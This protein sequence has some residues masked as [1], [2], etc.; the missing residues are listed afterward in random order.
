[1]YLLVCNERS[2]VYQIS[3]HLQTSS[4]LMMGRWWP[5]NVCCLRDRPLCNYGHA[6]SN[7]SYWGTLMYPINI[8]CLAI[9]CPLVKRHLNGVLLAG[10]KWNAFKCYF[11]KLGTLMYLLVCNERSL[12][13]QISLHLQTSRC[14]MA[15]RWWPKAV[16][17]LR[18]RLLCNYR[19][20]TRY[21]SYWG[22]LMYPVNIHCRATISPLAKRHLNG[23]SLAGRW[24]NSLKR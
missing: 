11:L 22:T 15:G 20:A 6:I 8:H 13:Y 16:Y 14:L 1:M 9:I 10:R 5:K 7:F 24:W 23:V 19:H 12:V 2:L 18:D 21:F 4:F 3:L 17:W